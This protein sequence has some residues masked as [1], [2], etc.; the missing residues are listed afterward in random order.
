MKQI[1]LKTSKEMNLNSIFIDYVTKNYGQ[2]SITEKLQYY[3][4]DFNQNSNVISHNKYNLYKI[5]DLI[6]KLEIITIKFKS[7]NCNKK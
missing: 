5:K 3:F 7:I 2:Q 1:I 4:S 6:L